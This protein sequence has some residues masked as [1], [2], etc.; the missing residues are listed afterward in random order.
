VTISVD[1]IAAALPA[2]R[3]VY[4]KP[5][6]A[7]EGA[8][9]MRSLWAV[10]GGNP[11]AGVTPPAF[12]AGSGYIPTRATDGAL[13]QGNPAGGANKYMAKAGLS[14]TATGILVFYDRLWACSGFGTV[15][16]SLQSITTP[17]SLTAGRDPFSG[18]D[19]EMW[20]EV[21]T[22][23]GA[24]GAD[25]TVTYTDQDGNTGATGVYTHPANAEAVGQMVK[26]PLADGDSGVRI[27]A[28]FQASASSGAAGSIGI[29]LLREIA[30]IPMFA[31]QAFPLNWHDL[32][33]PEV[34]DD[35]C[36]AA[37]VQCSASTTGV[38]FGDVGIIE[39]TP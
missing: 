34:Y 16:T 15:S 10:S 21:Y 8:G 12:S 2:G 26:V 30:R 17:G 22:A 11:I 35:A 28:S 7:S 23:P 32:G 4:M 39:L 3:L 37:Y 24:T 6:V 20:F 25:W 36:I 19:V 1:T 31:N 27:P 5:T 38:I 9:T 29:T 18:A 13:G 33:L 14:S